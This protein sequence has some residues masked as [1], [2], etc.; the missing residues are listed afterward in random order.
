MLDLRLRQS[1]PVGTNN[2]T[3]GINQ[4][5]GHLM[6]ADLEKVTVQACYGIARTLGFVEEALPEDIISL[7]D[8]RK[9]LKDHFG[10]LADLEIFGN[11]IPSNASKSWSWNLEDD[12]KNISRALINYTYPRLDF[13]LMTL[14]T[15]GE[16]IEIN[17]YL[18]NSPE[19]GP[20]AG[21]SIDYLTCTPNNRLHLLDV[22][23]VE[24]E[25]WADGFKPVCTILFPGLDPRDPHQRQALAKILLI[26]RAIP[27]EDTRTT[28]VLE[29]LGSRPETMAGFLALC[30]LEED[31]LITQ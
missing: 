15:P 21:I 18:Q 29:V 2:F 11:G 17:V 3:A 6:Y 4:Q 1:V 7:P 23:K 20:R 30:L 10:H 12:Q 22:F 14:M 31:P 19:R 9:W 24:L 26:L 27:S 28:D 8:F 16:K 5:K 13:P 25:F